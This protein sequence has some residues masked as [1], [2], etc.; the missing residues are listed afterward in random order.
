MGT[1]EGLRRILESRGLKRSR[2]S[3]NIRFVIKVNEWVYEYTLANATF[4][5]NC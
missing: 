1:E 2:E 4:W 5:L 3:E